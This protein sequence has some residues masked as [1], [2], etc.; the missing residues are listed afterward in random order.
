VWSG[1]IWLLRDRGQVAGCCEHGNE[2]LR[3]MQGNSSVSEKLSASKEGFCFMELS[4]L[5]CLSTTVGLLLSN[6]RCTVWF[7][8]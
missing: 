5:E 4:Y 6:A 1:L 3:C 2:P 7:R 8:F